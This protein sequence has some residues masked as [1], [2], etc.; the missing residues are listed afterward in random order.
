M[1]RVVSRVVGLLGVLPFCFNHPLSAQERFDISVYPYATAHRGEWEFEGHINFTSRGT[2]AFD[3][4]VA[5]TEGQW[6]FT[7]EV[8]RGIT[9]HFELAGYLLGAQVPGMGFEYA[10]WRLRSRVRAPESWGLPVNIGFS[11][12]YEN[13]QPAFSES[14]HTAEL[15]TIFERRFGLL[16]LIAD[17]TFE[18]DV[19]GPEHEWEFEPRARTALDVTKKVTLGF[20][21]YGVFEETVQKHQYYPTVDFRI[22]DD[23]TLHFGVGFGGA[24]AGD[25]LIFKTRF[26]IE[27]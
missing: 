15:T 6:R 9:D 22:G 14:A 27:Q 2:S 26:E 1:R 11:A 4:T 10:G 25:R 23:M 21:Y 19:N 7:A 18:R 5:P 3:G 16:Q 24:N 8:S 20:E 13:A 12:E 17:P